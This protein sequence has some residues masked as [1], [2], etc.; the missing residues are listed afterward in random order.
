MGG[1]YFGANEYRAKLELLSFLNLL[2]VLD[3][4]RFSRTMLMKQLNVPYSI[5]RAFSKGKGK[6]AHSCFRQLSDAE[7]RVIQAITELVERIEQA[8]SIDKLLN[9]PV[10]EGGFYKDARSQK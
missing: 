3:K 9:K 5:A 4:R 1:K 7:P 6:N 10:I 2:W 8:R